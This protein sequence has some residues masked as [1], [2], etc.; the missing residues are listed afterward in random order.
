MAQ[1][2][3]V[4]MWVVALGLATAPDTAAAGDGPAPVLR[5]D[6]LVDSTR[7]LPVADMAQPAPADLLERARVVEMRT[8]GTLRLAP[9][10]GVDTKSTDWRSSLD[11]EE[12][13][14]PA[15][16]PALLIAAESYALG[17]RLVEVLGECDRHGLEPWLVARDAKNRLGVLCLSLPK[18]RKPRGL[19]VKV[20]LDDSPVDAT[21][22][23]ELYS[24]CWL[25]QA[26]RGDVDAPWSLELSVAPEQRVDAVAQLVNEARRFGI[27]IVVRSSAPPPL[28][29]APK[30]GTYFHFPFRPTSE[31]TR[32]DGTKRKLEV[33]PL[34]PG[35]V[36][37]GDP[38][39]NPFEERAARVVPEAPKRAG[40]PP[41][42][43]GP[44]PESAARSTSASAV[45]LALDYL[46]RHRDPDGHWSCSGFTAQC[47]QNRCDGNGDPRLDVGVTGLALLAF[48][49]AGNAPNGREHR[50]E[51]RDTVREGLRWLIERQDPGSGLF[52]DADSHTDFLYDHAIA[53]L[54]MTQGYGVAREPQYRAS[55]EKA[56]HYI[57]SARNPGK[58]WRYSVPPNGEND[59]SVTGWMV[60]AL[61][62]AKDNGLDVDPGA[63]E[64]AKSFVDRMTDETTW[65]TGYYTRGGVSGRE[66][67][68][69]ERW[70]AEKSEAMTAVAM[71]CRLRFDENPDRSPALRGGA[72]LLLDRLPLWDE[73]QGTID[74][75]YWYHGTYAMHRMGG[76]DWSE[77]ERNMNAAILGSQRT[78]G[79]EAG[80]WDPQYDP[81][82][83]RGGRIYS[84]AILAL[85]LLESSQPRA[86]R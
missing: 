80:S 47:Q 72:D 33:P 9:K 42:G 51:H 52:G 8:N 34:E 17:W 39:I 65:R 31:W 27:G 12:L 46:L 38:L 5:L 84:T 13:Q 76:R 81:W 15:R 82:G 56:I 83:R 64:G 32:P 11:F 85:A 23:H 48:L 50:D 43:A 26:Q 66:P 55:A 59:V 78:D 61:R 86:T 6:A 67:G 37:G 19:N 69:A 4:W 57:E 74:Y 2:A 14:P 18:G 21:P 10:D 29:P 16:D 30:K 41:T 63:F 35:V 49:G 28:E 22:I 58:A 44:G 71:G 53:T 54:A 25:I 36:L 73:R 24:T 20:A 79:D 3:T 62:S 40:D 70:P 77:W 45:D 60:M 68:A 1:L 7:I 75:Y